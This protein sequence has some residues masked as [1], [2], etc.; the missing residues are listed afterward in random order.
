MKFTQ[1]LAAF[2]AAPGLLLVVPAFGATI[3]TQF[4]SG[5]GFIPGDFGDVTLTGEDF[6]VTFSGGQQQQFFNGPSY[7]V[8]PAAYFVCQRRS[9]LYGRFR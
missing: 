3:S 5:D 9:G 6:S 1:L 8:G 2:A 7:N 4:D